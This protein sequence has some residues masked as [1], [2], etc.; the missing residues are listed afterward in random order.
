MSQARNTV[1][2]TGE[3][4]DELL[5]TTG[6]TCLVARV[7]PGD[8]LTLLARGL[9]NGRPVDDPV[10]I[11]VPIGPDGVTFDVDGGRV[12]FGGSIPHPAGGAVP[13]HAVR[14]VDHRIRLFLAGDDDDGETTAVF[15]R[16]VRAFGADGQ[17][18][19]RHLCVGVVGAGGT[20]S[21]VCGQ[22]IRLGVGTILV[23]DDDTISD[24]GANVT[25]IWGS[26]LADVGTDKVD[27]V[28]RSA[29]DIGFGTTVIPVCGTVNDE[30]TARALRHCDVVF[31]CTDDN[32]GRVTLSRFAYWYLVP[33]IDMGAQI[34]SNAGQ[35]R[36]I[37]GRIT[38]IGPGTAC[39]SCR[40][41]INQE[42]L[43][44]ELLP[45]EE[46]AARVAERYAIGL[47]EEDPAVIAYTTGIAAFA[48]A[49]LLNRL[50]GIDD[51]PP[52]SELV[53]Q[54]H[55]RRIGGN[56]RP[57][58]QEHWCAD[59]GNLGAGDTEPFLGITWTS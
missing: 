15:D 17:R 28:A 57:P 4:F 49:E 50:F 41:R 52:A 56:T 22:L 1:V 45:P 6:R 23:I 42:L 32:R 11:A 48:V 40:G 51:D 18:L 16:Q 46:R 31:G 27:I 2:M 38:V 35:L 44:T 34:D 3:L 55:F 14:V 7:V 33:V 39:L 25:R 12:R 43:Q 58:E 5:T 8:H 59:P 13:L 24:D 9:C 21:A 26:T 20:G 10:E 29:A 53:A 54:F 36:S 47:P 30:A 19:L 37:D